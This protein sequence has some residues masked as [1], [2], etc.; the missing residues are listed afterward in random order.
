MGKEEGERYWHKDE[1]EMED[2]V[3]GNGSGGG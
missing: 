2:K 3:D 1:M